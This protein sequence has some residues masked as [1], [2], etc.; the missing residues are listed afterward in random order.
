MYYGTPPKTC[1]Y[2]LMVSFL[3]SW[4]LPIPILT[5]VC[6]YKSWKT[7]FAYRRE[8][9]SFVLRESRKPHTTSH[10][11]TIFSIVFNDGIKSH[12]THRAP[13][14]SIPLMDVWADYVSLFLWK[15]EQWTW[16]Y[17]SLCGRTD[18]FGYVPKNDKVGSHHSFNFTLL[19]MLH[20]IV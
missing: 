14:C 5:L 10:L 16:M 8:Q 9:T 19:R 11:R 2:L 3:V 7:Q 6:T 4:L 12:C 18:S 1:F 20:T 17:N 13:L 15:E